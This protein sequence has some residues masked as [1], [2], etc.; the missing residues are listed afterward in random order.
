MLWDMTAQPDGTYQGKI[1]EPV[2]NRMLV[3]KMQVRG[4]MMQF[5]NCD[6]SACQDVVWTRLR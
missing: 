4:N 6:G 2:G 5:H 1:W 3:A